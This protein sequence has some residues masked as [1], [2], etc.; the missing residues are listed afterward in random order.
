MMQRNELARRIRNIGFSCT[1]CGECCRGTDNL[2][3]VSPGEIERMRKETGLAADSIA[4][5]YPERI[6]TGDGGS[7]TF[8]W[9]L[10]KNKAGCRFFSDG[11]CAS[12]AARPWICRTY[13]F[14]LE[15]E[16]LLVS[17]CPG[18]G[19]EIS[20]EEAWNLAGNLLQRRRAEQ[21]EEE[22]VRSVLSASEIP[23]GCRVLV[24]GRGM[25]VL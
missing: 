18:T 7:I 16:T 5:P 24:D 6:E 8:E 19:K 12:Y 20:R 2:V 4:E 10:R 15:G 21:L 1:R 25:K 13:P 14:M 22:H 17:D 9:A 23:P 11:H 3:M